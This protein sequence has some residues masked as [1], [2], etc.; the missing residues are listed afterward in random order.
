VENAKNDINQIPSQ[1][2]EPSSFYEKQEE[3][4]RRLIQASISST[5]TE[6]FHLLMNLMKVGEM[7]K[8]AKIHHKTNQS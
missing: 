1:I 3:H 7:M 6:K 8:R 5:A 2:N 4:E